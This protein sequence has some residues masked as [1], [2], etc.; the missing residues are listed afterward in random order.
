MMQS[1]EILQSPSSLFDEPY[2]YYGLSS[3]DEDG[4][5]CGFSAIFNTCSSE[6][7]IFTN[8]CDHHIQY[9][10]DDETLQLQPLIHDFPMKFQDLT[11]Q[12]LESEGSIIPS[13]EAYS[14]TQ[15]FN[16]DMSSSSSTP[17]NLPQ[18]NTQIENHLILPHL[19]DAI[20]EALENR[21]KALAEEILRCI[22]N[23]LSPLSQT[24]DER[25]H[26]YMSLAT[27]ANNGDY[28]KGEAL[29]NSDAAFRAFYQGTPFGKFAHFAALSAIIEN[30]PPDCDAVHVMDSYMGIGIQ[31]I[32]MIEAMARRNITQFKLTS[33]SS[34][35]HQQG[36]DGNSTAP[37]ISEETKRHLY[38]H[39]RS[40][41]LNLKV[42][43]KGIEE[44]VGELKN[45]K[46]SGGSGI[47]EFLAFNCMLNLPHMANRSSRKQA[48]EF[49]KL[50]KDLINGSGNKGIIT[51]GDGDAFE[52][53][54]TSLNFK[55]FFDGHLVH[56]HAL[57]ESIESC[58]PTSFSE[59]RTLMESLFVAPYV[60][61]FAWLQNWQEMERDSCHVPGETEIGL[62]GCRLSTSILMEVR[63]MLRGSGGS[64]E[65]RIEGQNGNEI[66]LAWKGTELVRVSA[67][68]N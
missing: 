32:P 46:K 27:A 33:I 19:V 16:S 63:E 31:W 49:L 65:T 39:A 43:E 15:S 55:A 64:Y 6:N 13:Q 35:H 57:M 42:E 10:I 11:H 5:D 38:E 1:N 66:V 7:T 45:V 12:F 59:A 8:E 18:P 58:F 52:K 61:P 44:L 21:H 29:R 53:L 47:K 4:D 14:P 3:M 37:W 23:K 28:L 2:Y 62:E 51:F 54:K 17:L 68:R 60:S 41:G 26:F 48:M 30:M 24:V 56:Y 34:G 20:G 40:C 67:W 25:L 22:S 50:A 9:T 36:H